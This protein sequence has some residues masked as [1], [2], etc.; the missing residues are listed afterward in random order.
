MITHLIFCEA[1][2]LF[3]LGGREDD[4]AKKLGYKTPYE[5]FPYSL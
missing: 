5:V 4:H 1:F 3:H 2:Q